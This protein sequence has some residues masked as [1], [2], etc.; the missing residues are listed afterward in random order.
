MEA[1]IR[2]HSLVW[3]AGLM[4]ETSLVLP[5]LAEM[6]YEHTIFVSDHRSYFSSA[7]NHLIVELSALVVAALALGGD[8]ADLYA[9]ALARLHVELAHQV[10]PD[11]VNAEMATHYHVFVLEAL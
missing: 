6:I 8:L 2:V 5:T 4:R 9:P 10:L 11:G 3:C 1:A 7:N